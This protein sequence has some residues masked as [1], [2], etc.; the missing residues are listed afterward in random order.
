MTVTTLYNRLN[1]LGNY[2]K[3]WEV[4]RLCNVFKER[5]EIVSDKDFKPL[6]VTMKGIL[7]QLENIALTDNGDNRKKVCVGDFVI[8]SRSD[9][10]GS[11][12]TSKYEGSVSVISNVLKANENVFNSLYTHYLF[13]N[14]LFQEEFYF[15]GKGIVADMWSTKYQNMRNI[16]IPVP[17]IEEQNQIVRYIKAKEEKISHFISKKQRF[18]ELLKEQRQ[19]IV[20]KSIT[21]GINNN[22]TY[23]ESKIEWLGKIPNH[24]KLV[25]LKYVGESFIGLTYSPNDLADEGKGI[26][27]LRSSNIQNGKF[28]LDD[29]V[30]VNKE[31][32]KKLITKKGDILLCSRNGSAELIGKNILIDENSEGNTFGAFMTIFRSKINHYLYYFFNSNIFK[33]Q[34]SLFATS[35]INQ[36]TNFILSN[37]K[38]AYPTDINEQKEIIEYIKIET[39][40]INKAIVKAEREIELIKEYKEAMIA[41]AVMGKINI[42]KSTSYYDK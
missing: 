27:V 14:K 11:G 26:L 9:R 15:H 6:S 5:T 1:W 39:A 40:T 29:N 17:P 20:T 2:P 13:T 21:K 31:I 8:N 10:K 34:T 25:K 41:E 33:S 22:V 18:I 28:T 30:Y 42:N 37:M 32:S 23:K 19:S 24:W 4:T 7:P 16:V 36:L 38:I 3:H 35:T 12:G